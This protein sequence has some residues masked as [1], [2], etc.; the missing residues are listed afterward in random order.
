MPN[1]TFIKLFHFLNAD[2]GEAGATNAAPGGADT[3]DDHHHLNERN[4]YGGANNFDSGNQGGGP[5]GNKQDELQSIQYVDV[6]YVESS[7]ET[8][9][10]AAMANFNRE[11]ASPAGGDV[12]II[13]NPAKN[14]S[15]SLGRVGLADQ[16]NQFHSMNQDGSA[17][18][19]PNSQLRQRKGSMLGGS[20]VSDKNNQSHGRR[21][22]I[23]ANS[24]EKLPPLLSNK[25]I[26]ATENGSGSRKRLI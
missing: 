9:N 20:G 5:R 17:A 18:A 13:Y 2:A 15:K 7:M 8:D 4:A 11:I 25:N 10:E 1:N 6:N 21:Q 24:S 26:T 16:L 19:N 22:R 23:K 12:R 14:K 3:E